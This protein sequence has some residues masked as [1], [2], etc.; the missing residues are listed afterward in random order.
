VY[1]KPQPKIEYK[2]HGEFFCLGVIGRGVG[3]RN[4]RYHNK[5]MKKKK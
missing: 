2:D 3:E 5:K 1:K 4:L